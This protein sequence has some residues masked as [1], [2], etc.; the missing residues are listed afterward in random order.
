MFNFLFN[1]K[2]NKIMK[3]KFKSIF[4]VLIFMSCQFMFAQVEQLRQDGAFDSVCSTGMGPW[5]FVAPY[6]TTDPIDLSVDDLSIINQEGVVC[7]CE[8]ESEFSGLITAKNNV[9]LYGNGKAEDI[10]VTPSEGFYFNLISVKKEDLFNLSTIYG[11]KFENIANI[12]DDLVDISIENITFTNYYSAKDGFPNLFNNS[13]TQELDAFVDCLSNID[14]DYNNLYSPERLDCIEQFDELGFSAA[15]SIQV[16]RPKTNL[17]LNNV[18]FKE[19]A[20]IATIL[21]Y[22]T[23]GDLNI[24]NTVIINNQT[25]IG[26]LLL[27]KFKNLSI[28]NT[29]ITKN[30]Q[31]YVYIGGSSDSDIDE[32]KIH[33]EGLDV[34][35][36]RMLTFHI[37]SRN[38]KFT[39]ENL[40]FEKNK[41]YLPFML[42]ASDRTLFN[43]NQF[44][45]VNNTG[46]EQYIPEGGSAI[47]FGINIGGSGTITDSEFAINTFSGGFILRSNRTIF[48]ESIFKK[49]KINMMPFLIYQ[50]G[51]LGFKNTTFIDNYF[52][53]SHSH[54]LPFAIFMP[55]LLIEH[56]VSDNPLAYLIDQPAPYTDLQLHELNLENVKFQESDTN[57]ASILSVNNWDIFPEI[58]SRFEDGYPSVYRMLDEFNSDDI[59]S[60]YKFD[61]IN[62]LNCIYSQNNYICN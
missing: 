35:D 49:N 53:S 58:A 59:F 14:D 7:F 37:W 54:S 39:G 6:N 9:V 34:I 4:Y 18:V 36:N 47:G 45:F 31:S 48:N 24:Q 15:A 30:T 57:F 28:S 38:F 20:T 40:N 10:I 19:F 50:I 41:F 51:S 42:W 26:L 25:K 8:G 32:P 11:P 55:R 46:F 43:I 16:N 52:S 3:Y 27:D 21:E 5:Y 60:I 2:W 17:S 29:L 33:I 56:Y 1:Q 23:N 44:R 22:I 62:S 13:N 12:D 61:Q